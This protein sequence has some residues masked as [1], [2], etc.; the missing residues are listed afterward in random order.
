[1]GIVYTLVV[2]Q[3]AGRKYPKGIFL[4]CTKAAHRFSKIV[5]PAGWSHP[6]MPEL[7]YH[8]SR[9]VMKIMERIV[10]KRIGWLILIFF[11]YVVSY[12]VLHTAYRHYAILIIFYEV[13]P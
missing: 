5:T 4:I 10:I 2:L 13:G 6:S 7:K 1:M 12:S 9:S 3:Q 8:F 11:K